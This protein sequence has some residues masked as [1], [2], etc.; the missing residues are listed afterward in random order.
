LYQLKREIPVRLDIRSEY[1]GLKVLKV[2]IFFEHLITSLDTSKESNI[3]KNRKIEEGKNVYSFFRAL[4]ANGVC[5]LS[6]FKKAVRILGF[7]TLTQEDL[8]KAYHRS[9]H[10][11]L[12][13]LILE[14]YLLPFIEE[15][16]NYLP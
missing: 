14:Y 5:N 16:K 4:I 7:E 1:I 3:E 11:F 13:R 9:M 6:K 8:D 12:V 15:Y 2:I 10:D